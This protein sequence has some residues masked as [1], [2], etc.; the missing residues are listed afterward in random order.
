MVYFLLSWIC[1]RCI[2]WSQV[3]TSDCCVVC[4][5]EA[6]ARGIPTM[7]T[8]ICWSGTIRRGESGLWPAPSTR[9]TIALHMLNLKILCTLAMHSWYLDSKRGSFFL[10]ER[11][12]IDKPTSVENDCRE[13][14][15]LRKWHV[16]NAASGQWNAD[17]NCHCLAAPSVI[18]VLGRHAQVR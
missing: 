18:H 12:R 5:A 8:A 11:I 9:E 14:W 6:S 3:G 15:H 4:A 10:Q 16:W 7:P 2:Q 1:W 13:L 17:G